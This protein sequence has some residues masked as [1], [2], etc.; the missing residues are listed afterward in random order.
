MYGGSGVSPAGSPSSLSAPAALAEVLEQLDRP[1][2]P[3]RPQP[4]G[5]AGERLPDPVAERLEQEHLALRALDR[6]PRGHDPRVV[7]D[8][9]RIADLRRKIAR[10][11]GAR[12]GPQRTVVDEQP[13]LVAPLGRV[14][15]D[16]LGR[17][18]VVELG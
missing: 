5:R 18:V 14:L 13:R 17:Q 10:T 15:R 6:D 11:C 8:D 12:P 2:P 9:E 4:P 16:Q 7:D 1:V 3:P